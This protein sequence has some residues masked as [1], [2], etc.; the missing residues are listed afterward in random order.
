MFFENHKIFKEEHVDVKGYAVRHTQNQRNV[1]ATTD[2]AAFFS[3]LVWTCSP[4]QYERS[5]SIQWAW[6]TGLKRFA[7]IFKYATATQYLRAT[8]A[9][10]ED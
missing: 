7:P 2:F 8:E 5:R 6:Q 3:V 4:L 10:L 9:L 1:S